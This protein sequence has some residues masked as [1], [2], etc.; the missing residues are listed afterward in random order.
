MDRKVNVNV[1]KR[2]VRLKIL[3]NAVLASIL[4][5]FVTHANFKKI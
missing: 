2:L 3:I 4:I 1:L 5:N